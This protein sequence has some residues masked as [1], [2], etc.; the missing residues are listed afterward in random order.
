MFDQ[1]ASMF[2]IPTPGKISVTCCRSCRRQIPASHDGSEA[3]SITCCLCGE[4]NSYP[5]AEVVMGRPHP[6]VH[7]LFE[8][9]RII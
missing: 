5:S 4:T 3:C 9:S 6:L 1:P 2:P 7:R 8:S